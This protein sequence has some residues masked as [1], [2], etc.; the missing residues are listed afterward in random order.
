[1]NT[2]FPFYTS[3]AQQ[4]ANR[5]NTPVARFCPQHR[6]LPFEIERPHNTSAVTGVSLIDCDNNATSILTGYF[7]SVGTTH[8]TSAIGVSS[9]TTK[10]YI[11]YDGGPLALNLPY[12]VYFLQLTDD[13]G[14]YYSEH[15]S[16][17]NLQPEIVSS[18]GN[19]DTY[20]TFDYSGMS[21]LTA[22]T[23]SGAVARSNGISGG[24]RIGEKIDFACNLSVATGDA[25]VV[26]IVNSTGT[27]ISDSQQLV[28][29]FN[30]I[31][32]TMTH[33]T[34]AARIELRNTTASTYAIS[35]SSVRR[36]YGD[37]IKLEFSNTDDLRHSGR[38]QIL[39]STG[40]FKQRV[41]F[42]TRLNIPNSEPVEVGEE[43]D[44][45][46]RAEQINATYLYNIVDYVSRSMFQGIQNMPL[47]DTITITD[48]VGNEYSPDV[49]NIDVT[50]D[51]TTFDT[52][53]LRIQFNDGAM[54]WV[55][56]QVAIT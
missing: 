30:D 31:Q 23:A 4:D 2:T 27:L 1:M 6:L 5:V 21:I 39:Y 18:W 8:G 44:G 37:F 20:T 29:G 16:V 15:F 14:T 7:S 47:H 48:E 40:G 32:I 56:D 41:Y 54:E 17:R 51:W 35:F 22:S 25:P 38:D 3:T 19:Y 26:R 50:I 36:S 53:T 11:I 12:G 24:V 45:V 46:F 43:I 52:G 10:D 55:N 13:Y 33:S 49:G 34:S 9:F 28:E 42:D